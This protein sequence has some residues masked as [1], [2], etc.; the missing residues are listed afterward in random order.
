MEAQLEHLFD[1]LWPL[2]RSLTGNGNRQTLEILS[3]VVDD[4]QVHEVP[5]GTQCFDWTVPPEWNIRQAWIRDSEGRKFVDFDDNNL[6]VVGY[7]VPVHARL[8]FDELRPHLHTLPDQPDVVPYLTSYYTRRWG[9]CL[10]HAQLE[11]MDRHATYDVCIDASLDEGGSMTVGEAYIRGRTDREVLFTTYICHPSM[12]N[13]ELSGPLVTALIYRQLAGRTDLNFSYRFLFVPETV[14]SVYMLSQRGDFWR[15][16]LEAGFV[17]TCVGD[18]GPF[19]YKKSRRSDA[20]VDKVVL[21]V[22][23]QT[24]SE[25][26]V[27]DFAPFGSDERQYCSPGF[28]LP[29]GSLMRTMY[30]TYPE[31]HTSADNKAFISF[32][33]M[34]AVVHKY[35][36]I[37]GVLE[38]NSTYVSLVPYGEP[39]LG[40]R[41]LYPTLGGQKDQVAAIESMMWLLN[42]ADGRHDL[43][44]MS[45][46]SKV[47][48]K[49]LCETLDVLLKHKLLTAGGREVL[50]R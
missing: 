49:K 34:K 28:D 50:D 40:R 18:A 17:V 39:Q 35:V 41:G 5:S 24:E 10:N 25:Y 33:A 15:S 44:D 30:A 48:L 36:D 29:V 43:V 14:G 27:V 45:R 32:K 22:L 8:T 38:R 1:R 19:T 20:S 7:S 12:A 16:N 13:N 31:Y 6:H 2:C 26:R 37:V 3:D 11:A 23:E 21:A 4:M 42:L 47:S 46:R 9:F